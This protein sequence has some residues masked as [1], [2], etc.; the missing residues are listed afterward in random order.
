MKYVLQN[1]NTLKFFAT[2]KENGMS[3]SIDESNYKTWVKDIKDADQF[4]TICGTNI[5]Q[6]DLSNPNN[7]QTIEI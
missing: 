3:Y 5:I 2:R 7:Y 6:R 1:K 4:T